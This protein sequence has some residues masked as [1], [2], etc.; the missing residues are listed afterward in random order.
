MIG[1]DTNILV[2]FFIQDDPIQ[3][4]MSR[5]FLMMECSSSRPGLV[6]TVVLCEL[7]WTLKRVYG[8]KKPQLIYII[9]Q[10]LEVKQL[11][12]EKSDLIRKALEVFRKSKAD[13]SD[14]LVGL[15]NQKA[16][17]DRSETFDKSAS[18][19]EEFELLS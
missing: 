3:F 6:N 9:E 5:K 18:K 13:F 16:G 15:L 11:S 7:I 4:E 17:C 19:L 10:M 1:I 14:C 8:L 2:R 12:L